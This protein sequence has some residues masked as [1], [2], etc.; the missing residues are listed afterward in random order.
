MQKVKVT[1]KWVMNGFKNVICVGYCDLQILLSQ[2][3]PMYYTSGVYGWNADV[4]IY[5]AD[6]A[7]VT[8]YR[9][10]GNVEVDSKTARKYNE[11]AREVTRNDTAAAQPL[12]DLFSEFIADVLGRW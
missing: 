6:T 10:F 8:G 3:R 5:D 9:P 12:S 2:K 7:V 11:R 4:Y 1:K